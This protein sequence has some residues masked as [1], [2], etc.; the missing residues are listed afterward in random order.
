MAIYPLET[1]HFCNSKLNSDMD[2]ILICT[3]DD[4]YKL[5]N[6]KVRRGDWSW[7]D[8]K[9]KDCNFTFYYYQDSK[10]MYI[11]IINGKYIFVPDERLI[12]TDNYLREIERA[13][14][15]AVFY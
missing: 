12:T 11:D 2:K 10:E 4:C 6:Y 1:C 13:K 8:F 5:Y 14:S 7:V 3:N 9:I 15:L